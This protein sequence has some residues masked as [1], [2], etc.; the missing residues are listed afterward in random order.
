[1]FVIERQRRL[2]W[3]EQKTS[4]TNLTHTSILVCFFSFIFSKF[5]LCVLY[6]L[7]NVWKTENTMMTMA[8]IASEW[9]E[10]KKKSVP[11][12]RHEEK[13]NKKKHTE[14]NKLI[15]DSFFFFGFLFCSLFLSCVDTHTNLNCSSI[16]KDKQH[17]AIHY[18]LS[19]TG[20]TKNQ[21]IWSKA[22]DSN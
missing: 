10:Y 1:M 7:K 6:C 14:W 17:R 15:I 3:A 4:E 9:A 12:N 8:G 21:R 5:R 18:I 16:S 20:T 19:D 11:Y 2:Q 13:E 22:N